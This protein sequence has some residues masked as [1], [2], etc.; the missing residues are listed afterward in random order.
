MTTQV[1]MPEMGEGVVEGRL[2]SWFV[3]EGDFV[4]EDDPV[5]EIETDKVTVEVPAEVSGKVVK[6]LVP[7]GEVITVGMPLAVIGADGG[8]VPEAQTKTAVAEQSSVPKAEKRVKPDEPSLTSREFDGVRV[9]PVVA[10]MLREHDLDISDI[11]GT[12]KEGRVT[13]QD[14]LNHL[15]QPSQSPIQAS[16]PALP[17]NKPAISSPS[18]PVDSANGEI[19][20]L[21]GMR[22]SIAEHMVM[23]K[24]VS[25]HVTTVFEFDYSAVTKHR[26]EHKSAFAKEGIK[27]TYMPY[28]V[29]AIAEALK[30]HP[31]VNASWADAGILL[32]REVN[33][34]MAVAVS[35][36]LL[37][38]VIRHAD[39]MN[40]RGLAHAINDLAERGRIGKIKPDELQG[41]TFTV[42]NHGASGSLIGTPIINQPQVGILGVGMIEKRVKA[43]GDAIAIR[44]CAYVS[45]S[46]DHRILDGAT[47]DA[48]VMDIKQRIENWTSA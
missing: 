41:G 35:N 38:P 16:T 20:P 22:R 19:V 2:L 27:L 18:F 24:Q 34:G 44:P 40:L 36:G 4:R 42:T 9:S 45:F 15:D 8:S 48:F 47:A 46:F 6:I 43:I 17:P 1:T 13:K 23:S 28:L 26:A 39:T 33:I 3:Q 32:K 11:Q 5:L 12:G 29:L 25:P 31:M 37:V 7:A 30:K 14:V 10:R 21:T